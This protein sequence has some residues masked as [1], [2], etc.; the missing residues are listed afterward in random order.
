M[1][2]HIGDLGSV[3]DFLYETDNL[4]HPQKVFGVLGPCSK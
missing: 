2:L 1:P 3:T 4:Q